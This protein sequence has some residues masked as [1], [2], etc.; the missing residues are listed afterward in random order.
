[1]RKHQSRVLF[2]AAISDVGARGATWLQRLLRYREHSDV[3]SALPPPPPQPLIL[4]VFE[5]LY[6]SLLEKGENIDEN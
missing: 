2:I 5:S 6:Y 4:H 1:M 3:T